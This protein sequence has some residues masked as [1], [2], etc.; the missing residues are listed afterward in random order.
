VLGTA[1]GL[2]GTARRAVRRA[3]ARLALAR[4]SLPRLGGCRVPRCRVTGCRVSLRC[5]LRGRKLTGALRRREAGP[6]VWLAVAACVPALRRA[7]ARPSATSS[8]AGPAGGL[9]LGGRA[10]HDPGDFV[11]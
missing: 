7:A 10:G 2:G 9:R 11:L 6:S 5:R 8:G 3:V 4:G 1:S